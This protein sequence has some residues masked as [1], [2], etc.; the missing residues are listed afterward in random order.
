MDV[1]NIWHEEL[2]VRYTEIGP[3]GTLSIKSFF[4]YMQYAAGNHADNLGVGIFHLYE[5]NLL[6]VLSRIKLSILRFPHQGETVKVKTYPSGFKKL[7][8]TRQFYLTGTDGDPIAHASSCWLVLNAQTFRPQNPAVIYIDY[9]PMNE[10][11]EVFFPEIGKI[12]PAELED[13]LPFVVRQSQMDIN[14]HLNNSF[15]PSM[16]EDWISVKRNELV[17]IREIQINFNADLKMN[18]SASYAGH[19]QG[20]S[21][22]VEGTSPDGRNIFQSIG[23]FEPVN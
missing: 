15:Y 3:D 1:Q 5:K 12:A 4:D 20:N 23:I 9:L 14:R 6:W 8:V 7:F 10:A 17:R 19:L 21:F 18:D 11:E 22:H 13:P 16:A 2:Q